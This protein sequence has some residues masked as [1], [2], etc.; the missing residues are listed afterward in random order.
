M[1][2]NKKCKAVIK[3]ILII[4]LWL[5]FIISI[6][7]V[8]SHALNTRKNTP[9]N[10][11]YHVSIENIFAKQDTA[12]VKDIFPFEFDRAYIM[13]DE[14][15]GKHFNKAHDLK[16]NIDDVKGGAD[17]LQRIVFVDKNG[18]LVHYF[19]TYK[20]KI[21]LEPEGVVIFPD[22]IVKVK[23]NSDD[24]P[25]FLTFD[26][27]EFYCDYAKIYHIFNR[28]A[29]AQVRDVFSF[30]FDR[31]YIFDEY[32]MSGDELSQKYNLDINISQVQA[33]DNKKQRI[34]FVDEHGDFVYLFSSTLSEMKIDEDGLV[35]YPDTVIERTDSNSNVLH[36]Y[37]PR[38][39]F[40]S[41]IYYNE[42]N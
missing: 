11:D 32:N 28:Q 29:Q 5:A 7:S 3:H 2:L 10:N 42:I 34:V 4:V 22:T 33:E 19:F 6:H 40:H 1:G 24:P 23:K 25:M 17:Y 18:S 26:S 14:A 37:P 9:T 27:T 20:Y 36:P 35:I 16:L 12:Q 13:D 38:L 15:T 31:A 21:A 39:T 30:E 8:V 41:K